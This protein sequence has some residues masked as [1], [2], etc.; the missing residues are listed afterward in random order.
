MFRLDHFMYVGDVVQ[1]AIKNEYL[2]RLNEVTAKII[3]LYDSLF[4]LDNN[5]FQFRTSLYNKHLRS[6]SNKVHLME[7]VPKCLFY[8]SSID[9][10][11]TRWENNYQENIYVVK[12]ELNN[13]IIVVLLSPWRSNKNLK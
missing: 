12:R 8:S 7:K 1:H 2:W 4:F 11:R 5:R 10:V 9:P 13:C 3:S 6:A